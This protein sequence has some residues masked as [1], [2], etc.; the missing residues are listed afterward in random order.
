MHEMEDTREG[1]VTRAQNAYK[2]TLY[3][4]KLM[5]LHE[6]RRGS[7]FPPFSIEPLPRERSRLSTLMTDEM[8]TL[9]KQWILD[10][11]LAPNEPVHVPEAKPLNPIRRFYRAPADFIFMKALKPVLVSEAHI[12]LECFLQE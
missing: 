1:K 3:R 4:E 5:K 8:R 7:K 11:H 10:Q 12:H 6:E 9:R 2:R